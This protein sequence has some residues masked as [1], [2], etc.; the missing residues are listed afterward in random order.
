MKLLIRK[1]S[2]T[3]SDV[4]VIT[5]RELLPEW[6]GSNVPTAERKISFRQEAASIIIV[7]VGYNCYFTHTIIILFYNFSQPE[8]SKGD[9]NFCPP[10]A[11]FD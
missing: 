4:E 8:R 5:N 2:R 10:D 9:G 7:A 11:V 1:V 3:E 6:S